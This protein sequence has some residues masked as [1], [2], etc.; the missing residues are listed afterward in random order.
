MAKAPYDNLKRI[1]FPTT[2]FYNFLIS[3]QLT[4]IRLVE[5]LRYTDFF[6]N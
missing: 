2:F 3:F 4:E 1:K 5:I 6:Q